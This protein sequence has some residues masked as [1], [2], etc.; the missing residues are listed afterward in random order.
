[1]SDASATEAISSLN[2]TDLLRLVWQAGFSQGVYQSARTTLF[3]HDAA[4]KSSENWAY[5]IMHDP[6]WQSEITEE[7]RVLTEAF[8]SN[9]QAQTITGDAAE[10][11]KSTV[12]QAREGKR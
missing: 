12:R 11:I 1:M 9:R 3:D 7:L 4:L 5:R 2:I 8:L 10:A 6:I